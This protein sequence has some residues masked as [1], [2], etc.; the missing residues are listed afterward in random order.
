MTKKAESFFD[1]DFTKM[2]PDYTQFPGVN[3]EALVEGQRKTVAAFGA[4]NW[5]A[6]EGA[7]KIVRRQAEMVQESLGGIAPGLGVLATTATPSD[8]AATQARLCKDAY[9]K[10]AADGRE[11]VDLITKSSRAASA[12][13][14]KRIVE[15]LNEIEVQADK[16]GA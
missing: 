8:A 2:I 9:Q 5:A 12:P 10:A 7:Q 14:Q 15:S 13:I 1:F 11:L 6:F 16:L 3:L 4:A